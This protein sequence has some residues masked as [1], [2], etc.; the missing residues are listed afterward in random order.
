[1][2]SMVHVW[3]SVLPWMHRCLLWSEVPF[4][5]TPAVH[6]AGAAGPTAGPQASAGH[7]S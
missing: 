3:S 6:L 7:E 5:G 4:N 2:L 1:M